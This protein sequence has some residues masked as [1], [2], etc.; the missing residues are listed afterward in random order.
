MMDRNRE[1]A[2]FGDHPVD[3]ADKPGLVRDVFRRVAGRYDL[4]NDV[5]SG[6][7]HRLWKDELI[8]RMRPRPGQ[9]LLDVAGGTGDVARRFLAGAGADEEGQGARAILCDLTPAMVQVGRDRSIDASQITGLSYVVGDAQ[10]LPLADRSVDRVTIAFGLRN[11]ARIDDALEEAL[12]VLKPGGRYFCL[13]FSRMRLAPLRRLYDAYSFYA[14]PRI[15]QV[16]AGDR[17][18][19]AYLVESI[20]KFP[21]QPELADRMTRA[22]FRQVR[23]HNLSGGIAAI[24]TGWRL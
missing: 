6:G 22:G 18:A 5:M 15:G 17:D 20:R 10:A 9:I 24:H 8:S 13:E 23:W 1:A 4:M 19:Y 3:P 12:R 11:V 16:V 7:I 2:W 14:I 21:D